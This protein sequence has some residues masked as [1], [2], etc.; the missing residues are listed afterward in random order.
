MAGT[1]LNRAFPAF[2]LPDAYD[3]VFEPD[4]GIL[5]AAR[6]VQAQVR[7]AKDWGG[8]WTRVLENLRVRG[9]DMEG[10]R[11][12]VDTEAGVFTADRL[13]VTAGAW[14]AKLLPTW[15]VAMTPTRQQVVYFSPP[16][17]TAFRPGRLPVFIFKG[18][19]DADAFYGMPEYDGLGVK[20]ARH[21]GPEIDPDSPDPVVAACYISNIR[22][23]LRGCLPTL[24]ESSID[25]TEVCLYN[26]APD[27]QFQIGALPDRPDVFLASPCSGHGFKFTAL[28][29]HVL[30]DLAQR[31]ASDYSRS[32]LAVVNAGNSCLLPA[33]L[34]YAPPRR[35]VHYTTRVRTKI[36]CPDPVDD[37]S[38]P[39]ERGSRLAVVVIVVAALGGGARWELGRVSASDQVTDAL[40]RKYPNGVLMVCGGGAMPLEVRDHFIALAGGREANLLVI[41]TGNRT[42]D[43]ATP[44]QRDSY[45]EPWRAHGVSSV[46]LWHAKSRTEADSL[47][48]ASQVDSATG[49]WISGGFQSKL[50]EVYRGTEVERRMASLLSR[51]G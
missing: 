34:P 50:A 38:K 1:Q 19:D 5:A 20:V 11:P 33:D 3:A 30:A 29:G 2:H 43:L 39:M 17:P 42:F 51:G 18:R 31:G 7:L 32:H 24:A 44:A 12:A 27:D 22:E 49:V 14:T 37:G 9:I 21:V 41:P 16:E 36:P 25:S 23:F 47:G 40:P 6:I 46:R 26:V 35:T 4:A 28:I 8:A 13:I 15:P 48:F 45:L 10:E